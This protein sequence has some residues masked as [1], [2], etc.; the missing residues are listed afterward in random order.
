MKNSRS[1]L[2][3]VLVSAF[4]LL[5]CSLLPLPNTTIITSLTP[6]FTPA[7]P[8]LRPTTANMGLISE[9]L[10]A[11]V[12]PGFEMGHQGQ[13]G[14]F[15]INEM[16]RTG[17]TVEN[18]TTL[19]TVEIFL[20]EKTVTPQQYQQMLT[21]RWFGACE[22]SESYPVAEGEENGYPFVL[23]Q[24]YC[25]LNGSLQTVEYTYLKA[26]QG[27]DRFYLVQVAFRHEPSNDEITQ[28]MQYLK[29]VQVCD[30]RIPERACP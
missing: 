21:E 17:E 19:I 4:F 20:G 28:W 30:S 2:F 24:L 11:V 10:I 3:V 6:T 26:I 13:E 25:P 7:V 18:W 27:N 1:N 9:N 22:N 29:Q 14:S 8:P 15:I 16:V 12:P 23:W 5:A